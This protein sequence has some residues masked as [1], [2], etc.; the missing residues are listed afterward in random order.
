MREVYDHTENKSDVTRNMLAFQYLKDPFDFNIDGKDVHKILKNEIAWPQGYI[1][2]FREVV[3]FKVAKTKE[4]KF[5]EH[6]REKHNV[7]MA[8]LNKLYIEDAIQDLPK[9]CQT[10]DAYTTYK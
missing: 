1:P 10:T 6:L 9:V 3:R 4:E 7:K 8:P 5:Q 2:E